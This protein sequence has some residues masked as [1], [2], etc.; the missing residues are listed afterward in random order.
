M[1]KSTLKFLSLMLVAIILFMPKLQ[2]QASDTSMDL[3]DYLLLF[4]FYRE[5]LSAV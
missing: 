4:D 5:L 1:T 3:Y 2:V